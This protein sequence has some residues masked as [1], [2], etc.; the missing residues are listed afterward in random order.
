[1]YSHCTL[2]LSLPDINVNICQSEEEN[3]PTNPGKS[4]YNIMSGSL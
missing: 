4:V 3:Q 1:M 2:Y